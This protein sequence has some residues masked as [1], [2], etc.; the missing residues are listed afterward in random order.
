MHLYSYLSSSNET[1]TRPLSC[2]YTSNY[3][4]TINMSSTYNDI[5]IKLLSDLL[6]ST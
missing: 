4:S 2:V 1:I 3:F 5:S 6:I